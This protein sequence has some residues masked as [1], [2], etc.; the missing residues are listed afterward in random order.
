MVSL[1]P[2]DP[3]QTASPLDARGPHSLPRSL[4]PSVP[5]PAASQSQS[6]PCAELTL[7]TLSLSPDS[8]HMPHKR[9]AWR[10]HGQSNALPSPAV[11]QE[12][13]LA[14]THHMDFLGS[15]FM[16]NQTSAPR[17][18]DTGCHRFHCCPCHCHDS[19]PAFCLCCTSLSLPCT[20][21]N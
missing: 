13:C 4:N 20:G 12:P 18:E 10:H 5:A 7:T 8:Y 14:L 15:G 3:R 21:L 1:L 17:A 9:H 6:L 11:P 19:A 16:S 2:Q